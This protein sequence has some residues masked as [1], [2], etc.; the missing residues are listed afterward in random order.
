MRPGVVS[1]APR[2]R[3]PRSSR[4]TAG[5]SRAARVCSSRDDG[6]LR[7]PRHAANPRRQLNPDV[8]RATIPA[9][10]PLRSRSQVSI[11]PACRSLSNHPRCR[12]C[13]PG[14][15][16]S[17]RPMVE[18]DQ[19]TQCIPSPL[20]LPTTRCRARSALALSFKRARS[21]DDAVRFLTRS[22]RHM[23]TSPIIPAKLSQSCGRY[24]SP[25]A[26]DASTSEF[27]LTTI[28]CGVR[29]VLTTDA[30]RCLKGPSNAR[31]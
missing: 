31:S 2:D 3:A 26:E 6:G 14:R 12:T 17:R 5:C 10:M 13:R 25:S 21:R 27:A 16:I 30:T 29:C 24:K 23:L 20:M 28:G 15:C 4:T 11:S 1:S 19:R 8:G 18:A 22:R 9:A 7:R